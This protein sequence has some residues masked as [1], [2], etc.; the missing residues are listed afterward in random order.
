MACPTYR[1]LGCGDE[2]SFFPRR[3]AAFEHARR[4]H[5]NPEAPKSL[6]CKFILCYDVSRSYNHMCS[7]WLPTLECG[8]HTLMHSNELN[9]GKYFK[10]A[11]MLH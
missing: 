7:N 9:L 11:S 2:E 1:H 5:G 10:L 4:L 6:L 8:D 3:N